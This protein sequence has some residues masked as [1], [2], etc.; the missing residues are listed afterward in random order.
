MF[1][2]K[3][4]RNNIAR[5]L[6][7]TGLTAPKWRSHRRLSI[8]TFHRVLSE[9]ERKIYPFPG[10]VVTPEELDGFLA[11]FSKYFDC[12][13]LATQHERYSNGEISGRPLLA[14]TFDDAQ[15]DNY[16]NARFVL[17][18]YQIKA[19][20]FAPVMAIEQQEVLWHDLLG[21]SV[22]TLLEQSHSG[23]ERLTRILANSGLSGRGSRSL[24]ENIVQASKGLALDKR[25]RL[26]EELKEASG[27]IE[28]PSFARLMTFEELAEL[29]ADGHEI[30]SHSMTHC[31]MP[32]CD[33]LTLTYEIA[34]SR[35][36]LQT[37]LGQPIDSFCYPNGNSDARTAEAVAKAGYLRAVTTSWG[38]NEQG[39]DRFQLR[40]FNMNAEQVRDSS[41]KLMH[42]LIA[43][44]MSGFYPGLN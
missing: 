33:D 27:T 29:A 2:K 12:G 35:S 40:R 23:Q 26:V 15:Y 32:E 36:V 39:A 19:S 30:G 7:L 25:L 43:F 38:Y 31:L 34:E 9:A 6:F 21:F 5:Y 22:A 3:R 41:G 24:I 17:D 8:V 44:R 16:S 10:L 1:T 20:F 13:S 4:L 14:I 37:R 11:Y 42:A 28:V 18:R